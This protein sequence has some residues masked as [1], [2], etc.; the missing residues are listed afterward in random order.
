MTPA[1]PQLFLL[2][3]PFS[4]NHSF[5]TSCGS[6]RLYVC[7]SRGAA[8]SHKPIASDIRRPNTGGSPYPAG[9]LLNRPHRSNQVCKSLCL[10]G[11]LHYGQHSFGIAYRGE[12]RLEDACPSQARVTRS[13]R[14]GCARKARAKSAGTVAGQIAAAQRFA[15]SVT[16]APAMHLSS[17]AS[18]NPFE[19]VPK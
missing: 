13:N 11:R 4:W 3:N 18:Q 6:D 19:T 12:G 17:I 7:L 16:G 2:Q 1:F 14:V 10:G 5:S 9:I 8:T 15:R